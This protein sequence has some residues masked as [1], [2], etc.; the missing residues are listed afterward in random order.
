MSRRSQEKRRA[1]SKEKK[2][3]HRRMLGSSPLSRL[4]GTAEETCEC[5][6]DFAEDDGIIALHVLRPVCGGQTIGA[7]FHRSGL[8]RAEGRDLPPGR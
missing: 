6:M 7:F 2:L 3:A 5:W 1:K 8:H 4:A